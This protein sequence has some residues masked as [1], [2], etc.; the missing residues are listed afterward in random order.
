MEIVTVLIKLKESHT[1]NLTPKLGHT[2]LLLALLRCRHA[3]QN[4]SLWGVIEIP[5]QHLI[6]TL[7]TVIGF[8][9]F[10]IARYFQDPSHQVHV[11]FLS[12]DVFSSYVTWAQWLTFVK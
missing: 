1:P 2:A 7:W 10:P 12:L 3:P 9:I 5:H 11:V 4:L 8:V 6:L